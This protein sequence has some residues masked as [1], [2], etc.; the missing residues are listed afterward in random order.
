M[1]LTELV[2]L[3]LV[4]LPALSAVSWLT[5]GI[6]LVRRYQFASPFQR[7]LTAATHLLGTYAIVDWFFLNLP[8]FGPVGQSPLIILA[9]IRGTALTLAFLSILLASKWLYFGHSRSDVAIA[10]IAL[11]SLVLVWGGMNVDVGPGGWGPVLQR[12]QLMYLAWVAIQLAYI[13]GAV[14]LILRIYSARRDLPQRL[15]IRIAASAGTLLTLLA[16]WLATNVYA[17]L[18]SSGGIPWFSSLL[19]I[20]AGIFIAAFLPLKTEE[21]GEVFRAV[22]AVEQRVTAIYVFYRTGEPLAA[23]G[24]SRSLPLEPEQLEGILGLVGDFVETS[25]KSPRGYAVTS[26]HFDRLGILA[27]RGQYI[28]AAG[29]FEGP[30][31]DAL[32]S[33]LLRVIR[34]FEERRWNELSDWEAASRIA[35]EVADELGVLIHRPSPEP[36]RETAA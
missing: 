13:A 31:Y 23:L 9:D 18:A 5:L 21:V 22:S 1:D 2:N 7:S 35:D 28:I 17:T 15:R 20:P 16:S 4:V 26:M 36:R 25:M 8:D 11:G 14:V 24:A 6:W 10:A 29:V 19:W 32:R 3:L 34:S 30:A 33:E 12:N 27:V